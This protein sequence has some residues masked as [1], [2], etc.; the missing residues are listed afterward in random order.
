MG[1][2]PTIGAVRVWCY[3]DWVAVKGRGLGGLIPNMECYLSDVG[4]GPELVREVER[5]QLDMVGPNSTR[6][7]G[8]RTRLLQRGWTLLF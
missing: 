6:S 3:V 1:P 2:P 7:S 8:S 5:N 4:E